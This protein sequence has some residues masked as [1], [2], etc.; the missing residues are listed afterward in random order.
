MYGNIDG[1][2]RKVSYQEIER[3]HLNPKNGVYACQV[4]KGAWHTVEVYEPS[5]IFEAKDGGMGVKFF[6]LPSSSFQGGRHI[7]HQASLLPAERGC[8]RT[9]C[10][11]SKIIPSFFTIKEGS[12]SHLG[13][14]PSGKKRKTAL[15]CS[16]PLRYKVGGASK[17]S[18]YCVGWDRM[19]TAAYNL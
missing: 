9:Q 2:V 12:T 7:S 19:G 17:P 15:R 1:Y 6:E 8:N 10:C 14:L 13:L 3:I 11:F 16:E 5:V 18:P 4:P